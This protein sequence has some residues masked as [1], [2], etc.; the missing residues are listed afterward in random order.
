MFLEKVEKS[1]I[2]AEYATKFKA[3]DKNQDGFLTEDELIE[4]LVNGFEDIIDCDQED[5]EQLMTEVRTDKDGRMNYF[6][7]IKALRHKGLM[8]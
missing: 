7:Y 6:D 2:E 5:L 1:K 8:Q 3:L 4:G